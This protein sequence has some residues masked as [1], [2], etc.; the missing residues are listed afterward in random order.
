MRNLTNTSKEG[1]KSPMKLSQLSQSAG[2]GAKLA[3]GLLRRLIE[4]LPQGDCPNLIVGTETSDDGAVYQ[5]SK[6]KA[7]VQTVDFFPPMSDNPYIFGQIAAANAL[8]DIYAMG[9]EPV[10]ALNLVAYPICM[11]EDVLQVILRGGAE[12][13]KEAGAV[14]AGGH[15]INDKGLKYGLSVT[16]IVHPEKV[17]R[18][19]GSRSGDMLILT[20]PIGTGLINTAIKAEMASEESALQGEFYMTTLN[21]GVKEVFDDF[22]IHACTDITGFGLAGHAM[23]MAEASKVT[24]EIDVKA[25]PVMGKAL[26]YAKMGLVPEAAYNNRDFINQKA[27]FSQISEEYADLLCDPQTSGGLLVSVGREQS[28]EIIEILNRTLPHLRAAIIGE[29]KPEGFKTLVFL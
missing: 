27:D 11:G 22:E 4:N 12:K 8:S 13:V 16:G 20:K 23:E 5:I 24:F 6:D 9:G 26:E 15:S 21:K 3:P 29:V 7:I 14:I 28:L 18:N 1:V 10:T 17:W 25:V 19:S 2:C